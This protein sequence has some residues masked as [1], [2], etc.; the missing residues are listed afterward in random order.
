MRK[1]KIKK[2]EKQCQKLDEEI[3]LRKEESED[4]E[5]FLN[6]ELGKHVRRFG[7]YDKKGN[8]L[9]AR[10]YRPLKEKINELKKELTKIQQERDEL[11]TK[12]EIL[13]SK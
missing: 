12:I 4:M 13:K 3:K 8:E 5:K 7:L 11:F 6:E 9:F 10:L 2:L 1:R